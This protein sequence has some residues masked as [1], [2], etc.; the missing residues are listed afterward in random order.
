LL[1]WSSYGEGMQTQHAWI[2]VDGKAGP[3]I[4][5]R[6]A[7][8]TDRAHPGFALDHT[9]STWRIGIPV[10]LIREPLHRHWELGIGKRQLGLEALH[11]S[12]LP[13]TAHEHYT[14]P[15]DGRLDWAKQFVWVAAGDTF[16]I[17]QQ[18]RW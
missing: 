2:V 18:G 16:V 3:R 7:W 15:L 5:D 17:Q 14:P 9:G 11:A 4:A 10:P 13:A 8:T 12:A 6:L 1:G